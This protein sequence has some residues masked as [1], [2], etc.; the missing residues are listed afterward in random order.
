MK[1]VFNQETKTFAT[2][3]KTQDGGFYKLGER[4]KYL[5]ELVDAK[6]ADDF[7][8]AAVCLSKIHY[9]QELTKSQELRVKSIARELVDR[10]VQE[11]MKGED[12]NLYPIHQ[13]YISME[14]FADNISKLRN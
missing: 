7:T 11:Y 13:F 14:P 10:Y 3:F 4:E 9:G 8:R 5:Q 12:R 1:I 6:K 2:I